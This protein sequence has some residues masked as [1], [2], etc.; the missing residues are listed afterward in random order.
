MILLSNYAANI[1]LCGRR[2][3]TSLSKV[4][5]GGTELLDAIAQYEEKVREYSCNA[6]NALQQGGKKLYKQ[7]AN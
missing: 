2:A 5:A 6:I 1:Q 4:A 3:A 7:S